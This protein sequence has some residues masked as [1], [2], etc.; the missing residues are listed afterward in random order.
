LHRI[1]SIALMVCTMTLASCAPPRGAGLSSEVLRVKDSETAAFAVVPVTSLNVSQLRKWPATGGASGYNWVAA[2]RGPDSP[3]IRA[4]D[5]INLVIWD[6][7]ENSLLAA[8]SEKAVKMPDLVVSPA[9]TIFVPYL[10]EVVVNGQ[11]PDQARRQIQNA[12]APIVPSAQVQLVVTAGRQNSVDLVSGVPKPGSYPLPDRNYSILSLVAIGGGINPS[13]RNPVVRLLRSGARFD[14][15][16]D[17]LLSD[18]SKNITLRGGDQILVEEDQ[19]YFTALG[20]T[21]TQK[22]IYFE[23]QEMTALETMSMIGGL[24][25]ARADPKGVLILRDYPAKAVKKDG[26]GP[27]RQ[28]VVFTFDLTTAEGLFA[29]R[30]FMINPKDTVLVT[31][32]PLV[33]TRNVLSLIGSVLGVANTAASVSNN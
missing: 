25:P 28:Q 22:L 11:T 7:Q 29:A 9:G 17:L 32:A 12:L 31:E 6:S 18:P 1:V 23:K 21:G 27:S 8:K 33:N 4:G 13:L 16:A 2:Q 20:A 15:P 19:R 3:V 5:H 26:T 30:D 10:D 14:I 24:A